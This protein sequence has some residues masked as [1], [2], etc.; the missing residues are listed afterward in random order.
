VVAGAGDKAWGRAVALL[1]RQAQAQSGPTRQ[2]LDG[3]HQ[4]RRA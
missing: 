4:R 1:G 2:W 3:T